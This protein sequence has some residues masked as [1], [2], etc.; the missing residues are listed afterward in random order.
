MIAITPLIEIV[1]L[2]KKSTIFDLLGFL[3]GT[4]PMWF[5][6]ALFGFSLIYAM[7]RLIPPRSTAA[8][9]K[10]QV[11]PTLG[12]AVTLIMIIAIFAFLIKIVQPIGTDILNFQLCYFA[13]YIIL[14]IVGI[15]AYRNNLFAKIRYRTGKR[16]LISAIA[17]GFIV[18]FVL[19][20]AVTLTGNTVAIDGGLTWQSAAY[21]LWESFVAVAMSIGL[22]GIFREKFNNQSR[23]VKILSDNS[24]AVY[25]F[26]PLIIV[27][28]TL[29]LSPVHLYSI[30][31]WLL[32]CAICVPFCFAVAQFV[33]RKIPLLKNVL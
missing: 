5:A 26:H 25:M 16:W 18:W 20:I 1:E 7:V 21:S 30:A 17:L 3:L 31:K 11:Q 2:G 14:F 27:A 6:A 9:T 24:F 29:F 28:V 10:K 4:G 12:M 23:L 33:F 8:S 13:S 22:I 32:F 19:V 15:L